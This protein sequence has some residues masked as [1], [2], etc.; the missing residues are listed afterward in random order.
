MS[1]EYPTRWHEKFFRSE[2]V[3]LL[4]DGVFAIVLTLLVLDLKTPDLKDAKSIKELWEAIL[5]IMPHIRSFIIAFFYVFSLWFFHQNVFQLMVRIDKNIILFNALILFEVCLVPFSAVLMGR[6]PENALA[7]II[8][9]IINFSTGLTFTFLTYYLIRKKEYI[10]EYID[11]IKLK[12]VLKFSFTGPVIFII[13][14]ALA[15]YWPIISQVFYFC[16]I[17]IGFIMTRSL[18]LKKS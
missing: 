13:P 12:N 2:R 18:Q 15:F 10:T 5:Q 16:F 9:G 6:Y 3:E 1:D 4:S 7:I 17:L 11:F 8:F 14:I